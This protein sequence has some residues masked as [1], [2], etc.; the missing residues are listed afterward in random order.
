MKWGPFFEDVPT[1]MWSETEINADTMAR[2]ILD[3]P[4]FDPQWRELGKRTMEW[5]F[6]MFANREWDDIGATVIN[7]QTVY[8]QPGNSHTSRHASLE[9]LY[10]EKTGDHS[11]Q[12]AAIRRLNWATYMV[13]TDG[14]NMYP[15]TTRAMRASRVPGPDIG[16]RM[17]TATM[18]G[19]T[20]VQWR[21]C[22]HLL[23]RNR[24]I[25]FAQVL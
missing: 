20:S 1:G 4:G 3:N 15:A 10:G 16:L 11:R 21:V 6:A 12:E 22:R 19:T 24:I 17:A 9:L 25:C 5:S 14:K 2:Y 23:R 18:S 7:E 13:D 8:K